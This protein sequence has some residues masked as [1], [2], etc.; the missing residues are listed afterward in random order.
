MMLLELEEESG[1]HKCRGTPQNFEE[2]VA[3][4]LN[5][6]LSGTSALNAPQFNM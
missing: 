5:G 3:E 6:V 1:K 4:F 2:L